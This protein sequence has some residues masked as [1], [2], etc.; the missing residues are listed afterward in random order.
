[1]ARQVGKDIRP[2]KSV[3]DLEAGD[4]ISITGFMNHRTK[5]VEVEKKDSYYLVVCKNNKVYAP[6]KREFVINLPY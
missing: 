1:M 3:E 6:F 2:K 4:Y 5:V